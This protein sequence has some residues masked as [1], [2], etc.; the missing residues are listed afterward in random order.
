MAISYVI[1]GPA[2]SWLGARGVYIVGGVVAFVGVVAAFPILR[3]AR[4]QPSE[5]L[6]AQPAALETSDAATLLVP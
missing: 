5:P 6:A 4:L 2:V 1:A 3:A